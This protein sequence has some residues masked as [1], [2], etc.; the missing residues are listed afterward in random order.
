MDALKKVGMIG[1][2]STTAALTGA[3]AGIG[4][5]G[6]AAWGGNTPGSDIQK[7]ATV[8]AI[9]GAALGATVGIVGG[10][11]AMNP[12]KT[13]SVVGGAALGVAETAGA[14]II[15]GAEIAGAGIIGFTTKGVAPLAVYGA[16]KYASIGAGAVKGI[17]KLLLKDDLR[18]SN[19]LGKKLNL[20]G[21]GLVYGSALMA[22]A[23]EAFN[24]FNSNRMGQRDGQITRATPRTP[25]YANNAGAT[26]DL[27]F[28]MNR[29]RRG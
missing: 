23:K 26:G 12:V 6:G 17:D 16:Q 27:V 7:N 29:N 25:S 3:G 24:D 8:G 1:A 15:G 14:G 20:A 21:K 2:I 9:G 19:L 13:A 10:V 18:E 28:A 5:V 11:A 22:G 4:Y